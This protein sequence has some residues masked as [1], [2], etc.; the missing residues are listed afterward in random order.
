MKK[1]NFIPVILGLLS[2]L[3]YSCQSG[4]YSKADY[5]KVP[6]IDA[7]VHISTTDASIQNHSLEENIKL[8]TINVNSSRDV[9]EQRDT[10]V[11]LIRKFPKTV[12]Y[13]ATFEFD[14]AKWNGADWEQ[15]TIAELENN[16]SGGA[17]GVKFW[18]NIGMTERDRAGNF[19]MVSNKRFDPVITFLEEKGL[20]LTGHLGEP[21]NCW[22]PVDS[23]TVNNDRSYFKDHPEYHMFLHPEYPSY[24]DQMD[25]R[26]SMLTK[27]PNLKFIGCHLGSL[28]WDVDV[29]AKTLDRFPNM[30]V[31]LAARICHLQYQSA[32]NKGKVRDFLI[33]YQD[34][35]LYGTD[36]GYSGNRT[37]SS[38]YAGI[39]AT[40]IKDWNYFTGEM[41]LQSR[42]VNSPFTGLHLPKQV[43][44]K[45][46]YLNAVKWYKLE[47]L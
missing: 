14:T 1:Q 18:K 28:E 30:A 2:I 25:A 10:A 38:F 11:V 33:K 24:Q 13:L 31:D 6:K 7:H 41:E 46:F 4:Y 8:I 19:I 36:I 16:I 34:R 20:P 47:D 26:D 29:L 45:I 32:K 37:D 21:K 42:D 40:R 3:V 23:M 39:R 35:I 43:V 5:F 17:V 15:Q 22:M 9:N 12:F 27:H 44:D